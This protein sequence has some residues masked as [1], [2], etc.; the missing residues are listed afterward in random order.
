M[1]HDAQRQATGL[2][3]FLN[4]GRSGAIQVGAPSN[5]LS[6]LLTPTPFKRSPLLGLIPLAEG[7][8]RGVNLRRE[9]GRQDRQDA[10]AEAAQLNVLADQ[11][12]LDS[13]GRK[14][15]VLGAFADIDDPALISSLE[16]FFKQGDAAKKEDAAHIEAA[17]TK[18]LEEENKGELAQ[19]NAQLIAGKRIV[20]DPITGESREEVFDIEHLTQAQAIGLGLEDKDVS[21]TVQ[22]NAKFQMKAG[23]ADFVQQRVTSGEVSRDDARTFT[24]GLQQYFEGK[25]DTLPVQFLRPGEDELIKRIRQFANKAGLSFAEAWALYQDPTQTLETLIAKQNQLFEVLKAGGIVQPTDITSM[26]KG[27]QEWNLQKLN[28]SEIANTIDEAQI[29]GQNESLMRI[30]RDMEIATGKFESLPSKEVVEILMQGVDSQITLTTNLVTQLRQA[31][32]KQLELLGVGTAG[33]ERATGGGFGAPRDII[34]GTEQLLEEL[35]LQK[36]AEE[37]AKRDR[38]STGTQ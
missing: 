20:E 37:D 35:L 25:T 21:R 5:T 23:I 10:F 26:Q 15:L 8:A 36:Q 17:D 1:P 13:E 24:F 9:V 2:Q 11:Q 4:Q 22:E 28:L 38:G 19:L 6:T 12:G 32:G 33:F 7:V 30:L 27:L 34:G 18:R 31:L 3:A 29:A 16:K 14:K